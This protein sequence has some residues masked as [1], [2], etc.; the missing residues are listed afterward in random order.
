MN[1]QLHKIGGSGGISNLK[2]DMM[3][4]FT[5]EQQIDYSGREDIEVTNYEVSS[6][7]HGAGNRNVTSTFKGLRISPLKGDETSS[8]LHSWI[9]RCETVILLNGYSDEAAAEFVKFHL[10]GK[11]S[12]W[13]NNIELDDPSRVET[14]SK[15]KE[16]IQRR[17]DVSMSAS[18]MYRL[19]QSLQQGPEE[20]VT[21][22]FD[23]CDEVQHEEESSIPRSLK[24]NREEF[25]VIHQHGLCQKFLR[26][27]RKE[28][29][30]KT[31]S[32]PSAKTATD[33]LLVAQKIEKA[34]TEE[35]MKKTQSFNSITKS[36]ANEDDKL[37]KLEAAVNALTV[38]T[39]QRD[40][41]QDQRYAKE[42]AS[43]QPSQRNN[44][45]YAKEQ[46]SWHPSQ[47]NNYISHRN[48][49]FRGGGNGRTNFRNPNGYRCHF[50]QSPTH[51][52]AR[53]Y[54]FKESQSQNEIS[55]QTKGSD[56]SVF[57]QDF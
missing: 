42:Q 27:L 14:W 11:S 18:D 22:F 51:L 55:Y 52:V 34:M 2:M 16:E 17:F 20:L 3:E 38:N 39:S 6:K 54:K 53:C 32:D 30:Q 7:V 5:D 9:K 4:Q 33:F 41:T 56:A 15:L 45:G 10:T 40:Y 26:G 48:Q 49:G 57:Y 44:F 24:Q 19:L 25:R 1:K 35:K 47:R 36:N 23:R 21:D 12:V 31:V 46:A 28:L 29:Q 37:S 8:S 13:L 43:W 50:C